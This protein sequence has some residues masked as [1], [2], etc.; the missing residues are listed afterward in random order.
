MAVRTSSNTLP[1]GVDTAGEAGKYRPFYR[2]YVRLSS[3]VREL[4]G[5]Q[6]HEQDVVPGPVGAA[7]G[8][9]LDSHGPEAD[10]RVRTDG[11]GVVGGGIDRQPV[12]AVVVDQV[13]RQRPDRVGADAPTVHRGVDV[14]VHASVAVVGLLLG[15]PLDPADD[16]AVELDHVR[17]RVLLPEVLEHGGDHVVA[18]SPVAVDPAG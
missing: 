1:P 17:R 14:D 11:G 5:E 10:L 3:A 8:A 9:A 15:L 12:V 6:V 4:L 2:T 18:A 13:P 7:F 16:A